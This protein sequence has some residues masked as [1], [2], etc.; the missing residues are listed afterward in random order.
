MNKKYIKIFYNLKLFWYWYIF[1]QVRCVH[2]LAIQPEWLPVGQDR[3]LV[4]KQLQISLISLLLP[5]KV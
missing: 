4:T 3:L 1:T 2:L 5:G